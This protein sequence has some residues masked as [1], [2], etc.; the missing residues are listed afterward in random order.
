MYRCTKYCHESITNIAMR[1]CKACL[2]IEGCTITP[3]A[4]AF[5]VV[6]NNVSAT[7]A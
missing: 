3:D 6:V 7:I 2:V 5:A 4:F 1:I